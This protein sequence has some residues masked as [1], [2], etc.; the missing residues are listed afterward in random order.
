MKKVIG[1]SYYTILESVFNRED[2]N[3]WVDEDTNF[4]F[5]TKSY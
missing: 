5:P 4:D 2:F 3:D 1:I